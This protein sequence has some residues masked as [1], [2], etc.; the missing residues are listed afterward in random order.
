MNNTD[1]NIVITNGINNNIATSLIYLF[2][3]LFIV[4]LLCIY[5]TMKLKRDRHDRDRMVVGF[6]TT[7]AISG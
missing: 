7:H 3:T 4:S 6:I 1:H 2:E 5:I